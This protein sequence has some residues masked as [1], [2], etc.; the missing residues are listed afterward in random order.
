MTE[1]NKRTGLEIAITGMSGR[2]PGAG[3]I[4]QFWENLKNGVN[5]IRFFSD[6]ELLENPNMDPALLEA[7]NY[8]RATGILEGV[9]NFDAFFFGYSPLEAGVLDPQIRIFYE[10]CWEALEDGGCDP[11]SFSG[12]IGVY[13]GGSSNLSWEVLTMISGKNDLL[14]AF[15]AAIMN[16]KDYLGTRIAHKLDLKGPSL[17]MHTACSTSLVAVDLACR[18]L[19]TGQCDAAIA[20]GIC[21][22]PEGARGG[23]YLY[24]KDL[25][26][27]RDGFVRAFDAKASGV[28]FSQGGGAVLL[29]RLEDAIADG[30]NIYAVIKGFASNND[31]VDKSSFSAPSVDGQAACIQSALFMAEVDPQSITY[32][33]THGTGTSIGDPIEIEALNLAFMPDSEDD[34]YKRHSCAIGSLKTNIGHLDTGAGIVNLIKAALMITH[35]Q[36]PPSLNFETPNPKIDFENS[37]FYVNTRLQ[38]WRPDGYPLRA[39]VSS[40]GVGG[41]NA[42]VIV[43][44]PPRPQ[45][46]SPGRPYHLL[47]LSARSANAL[48]QTTKN[49]SDYLEK[50]P[51][52]NL[53]DVAFTLQTGRKA[54]EHKRMLVCA[55][56]GEALEILEKSGTENE[57]RLRTHYEKEKKRAVFMFPGQG[58][59]YVNMGLQLYRTEPVF[60]EET[61]R[62]FH[63]LEPA[64]GGGIKEILYPSS[65]GVPASPAAKINQTEITQPV[66]FTMEYALARLLM[67]WG[68]EPFAMI[69]HSIGEYVAACLSGVFS[70]EDALTLV[71]RRGKLMQQMPSGGML[72]IPLPEEDV[73]ELL[74][75]HRE[76]DLA[77]VNGPSLCV[78]SGP[79]GP[80]DALVRL[81][82]EKGLQY[83]R[84]HT[85]HAYHS[86]MME[87]VLS[88]FQENVGQVT[89]EEPRIPFISNITGQWIRP[90]EALDPGY[91][92]RH[93]RG[94]VRFADG[95]A[96]LLKE[97][98][99]VFI[100]VGPGRTLE[101]FLK[102]QP[103]KKAEQRSITLV[104]HPGEDVSDDYYLLDKIGQLWLYG[105]PTDWK[106]FY[107]AE[108][109]QRLRLPSYPFQRQPYWINGNP[110]AMIREGGRVRTTPG[111]K[112]DISDWFYIPA[113]KR[114][115]IER[116][117]APEPSGEASRQWLVFA[118]DGRRTV[119]AQL[120]KGL[121][122]SV[123]SDHI[124][125][126]E[127]SDAFGEF[128]GRYGA[129]RTYGVRP[130]HE[131]DYLRLLQALREADAVPTRIV[132]LWN[133]TGGG[134][135]AGQGYLP[136]Q[137]VEECLDTGFYSLLYLAKALG[138]QEISDEIQVTV[139]TDG[140]RDVWERD[141]KCPEKA[142][143]LGPLSVIPLEYPGIKCR[144][145]DMELDNPNVDRLLRDLHAGIT[146]G[147]FVIAY[148][149]R[150][151]YTGT[152]QPVRLNRGHGPVPG[153]RERGV[154]LITGGLG[155][156]GL[157]LARH[158]AKTAKARLILT[159]RSKFPAREEWEQRLRTHPGMDIINRKIRQLKELE[160]LGA[161]VRVY[162]VDSTDEAGMRRLVERVCQQWGSIHGVIHSAGLPG[163][164]LIQLKDRETADSVLA[165][166]IKGAL[167]LDAA[168][169]GMHPDFIVLCSSVGS[170]I[171]AI[172]QVDYFSANAFLDAFALYKNSLDGSSTYTVSINWDAW[173]E[174]GMAVEAARKSAASPGDNS[175]QEL[176]FL[177]IEHPL[178]DHCTAAGLPGKPG[179]E[180]YIYTTY[181][182]VNR[183]WVMS[184][185]RS[186]ERNGIVPGVTYL[187][188]AH[189]AVKNLLTKIEDMNNP[190]G[191]VEIRD[192]SFITPL[193]MKDGDERETRMVLT[194]KGDGHDYEFQ[195]R[196]RIPPGENK[197]EKHAAG[198]VAF[199][200]GAYEAPPARDLGVIEARCRSEEI[201][202]TSMWGADSENSMLLFGP[203]WGSLKTIK[204]GN[205]EGLALM[206]LPGQFLE[207]L[208]QYTLYPALLDIAAAF[209][210]GLIT[211]NNPYIPYSYKRLR[212]Y[213][214]LP[215]AIYAHGRLADG[216]DGTAAGDFLG[217]DVTVMDN[218]GEVLVEIEGFTM[219]EISGEVLGR[220]KAREH[221]DMPA[222]R[223]AG[224]WEEDSLDTP[225]RYDPSLEDGIAPAEG[226]EAF[227]RI[228]GESLPQVVVSTRDLAARIES[229]RSADVSAEAPGIPGL[230]GAGSADSV[231]ARPDMSVPYSA[232]T[233][234]VEQKMAAIW[235]ELLGIDQVGV[236]DDFFELGGDSLKA[237]VLIGKIKQEFDT[238][239]SVRQIFNSPR[240]R[241]LAAQLDLPGE[242]GETAAP[243]PG[244]TGGAVQPVEKRRFYPLSPMQK[245]M[246]VLSRM[247]G[248]GSTYNLPVAL[249]IDKKLDVRRVERTFDRL[250]RRHESLRT[251]FH[252]VD[253]QPV[254]V[255]HEAGEINFQV[256]FLVCRDGREQGETLVR[257]FIRPFDLS[258][259][260]LL[261]AQ[262]VELAG[263]TSM[264]IFDVHH[265]VVDGSSY[266]IIS[267]DFSSLYEDDE[268][269]GPVIQYKDFACWLNRELES[270]AIKQQ[271]E[272]WLAEFSGEIP[273]L[274]LPADY[275]RPPIQVFEGDVMS[276][277]VNEAVT[278]QLRE[279]AKQENV[280]LFMVLLAVY[281]VFLSRLSGQEDMVL[282]T[283]TAGRRLAEVQNVV[284]MFVNTLALRNYPAGGKRFKDFLNQVK[285]R[286]LEAF[287][288]QDYPF[289]ILVENV[290]VRRDA[291]RNPL[292]DVVIDLQSQLED[293]D[294]SSGHPV[295]TNT[296]VAKFDFKLTVIEENRR[297][298]GYVEYC[299]RL[300]KPQTIE[301]YIRYFKKTLISVL[302]NPGT[303]LNRVDILDS[304]EKK[305]LLVDF[306]DTAVEYPADRTLH[307]LFEAQVE[308]TPDHIA[309]KGDC[310]S[311]E[312]SLTYAGL[313]REA[314]RVACL[315]NERGVRL[316]DIVAL[317][318]ERSVAM[319]IGLMG[320]LKA[321]A[322]YLPIDPSYPQERV[323]YILADSAAV[324]L[325]TAGVMESAASD[326]RPVIPAA[327]NNLAYV[328]YTSGTTGRP[329]GVM[330]E[331]GN[332]VNTVAWFGRR[333]GIQPGVRVVMM[334]DYTFD[335]SVNQVF[336]TLLHGGELHVIPK[337]LVLDIPGLRNFIDSRRINIINFVPQLLEE[338]LTGDEKLDSLNVVLSGA[339]KLEDAVKDKIIDRGYELHN[340]YGPTEVT[341]DALCS[342]CRKDTPVHL[343]K[344]IDNVRCYILDRGGMPAPTGAAGELHVA[345]AGVARGYLNSPGSTHES[346]RVYHSY[347]PGKIYKTG[348]LARWL[349]DGNI[350][351]LGR[352]DHQLKIKG[353]RI[354][355]GEIE[356]RLLQYDE[357]KQ[358]IVVDRGEE[359]AEKHLCA[360]IVPQ[361]RNFEPGPAA[362]LKILSLEDLAKKGSSLPTA[363][364]TASS[365]DIIRGLENLA[366][367]NPDTV[368]AAS[369][370][371]TLG[372]ARCNET[373]NRLARRINQLYDDRYGLT[374][375]E[376]V[377]YTRQLKLDGW[378]LGSQER[379]KR[380]VVFVAGAGGIG[381]P[382]LQQLALAGVGS[383]IVCD[384]DNVELSNLNRQVLH[385]ESR[386]GMNKAMSAAATIRRIN[387]HVNVIPLAEK[388]TRDNIAQLAGRAEI[389]FDCVDDL[390][391]KFVLSEYA[392]ARE[393]PHVVS[394]MIDI[395]S[396]VIIMHT[397]ETPCYHCLTDRSKLDEVR[398]VKTAAKSYQRS[399]FPVSSPALFTCTGFAV[400]EALKILLG[401]ENPAYN[402]YFLFN[403][404]AS[405]RLAGTD[406]F[407]MNTYAYSDHFKKI[408]KEQGFDWDKA[409][410][411][412]FLE[413]L[414]IRPDPGCPVCS[415]G[416]R[417]TLSTFYGPGEKDSAAGPP[418]A[419]GYSEH[420]DI[421][422]V[423]L[424]MDDEIHRCT[425]IM[426]TLKA[427][428]TYF[429]LD[430]SLPE[431][432]LAALLEDSGAR[433]IVTG[434]SHMEAVVRLRDRVN[435]WIPV[436][437]VDDVPGSLPAENLNLPLAP[438]QPAALMVAANPMDNPG[439]FIEYL[440]Q[441]LAAGLPG[442]M[443]P[444]RFVLLEHLPLTTQGKIDRNAL[445]APDAA[446]GKEYAAPGNQVQEIL[447]S[448]WS[449]VL[450]LERVGINDNF[451]E[452]G[453]DSIKAIRIAARMRKHN[454]DLSINE[455]FLFPEIRELSRC[456]TAIDDSRP[457]ESTGED[458]GSSIIGGEQLQ[459]LEEDLV[460]IE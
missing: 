407:R 382:T 57:T 69:G 170:V 14:G 92:S 242:P 201:D 280:T 290:S 428:K 456:V 91:W 295:Q 348:D 108:K 130:G 458:D 184:E 38:E 432:K 237:A 30:D 98:H 279:L 37:R 206:E 191:I 358:A 141:V 136:S 102:R 437:D 54:F 183:H 187:E 56:I 374:R 291:S 67:S 176:Q 331:H 211:G 344:P 445:P 372:A 177:P 147:D 166:K 387:P 145:I 314:G 304:D 339:E 234:P 416:N 12:P 272:F 408:C 204:S 157:A 349:P 420:R 228:L 383:I 3:N 260:P 379:L 452:I 192:V 208:G 248:I 182:S 39:G 163:G 375:E 388:I 109:R 27:S 43:E 188:M 189:A 443:M 274:N 236:N 281:Y 155:G 76:L 287:E 421:R 350:E 273:V 235:E 246:Y 326:R 269:P 259:A 297:L 96:E 140:M 220:L 60:R 219:M 249:T 207:D 400:N 306:N 441:G 419:A 198:E 36:I 135:T 261:R 23:G 24:E 33:E 114:S 193:M 363:F 84:L 328:I 225:V 103:D 292:F 310:R 444:A 159:G 230:Q 82:E 149:G 406:G 1:D 229:A 126:V 6:E 360:Y 425:A 95:A 385:D 209:I 404:K 378:V 99:A 131:E 222:P 22:I 161:E 167:A 327:K 240:V 26:Y 78:V 18:G 423:A 50:N 172:G 435:R 196:S 186:R 265:I 267:K 307:A 422:P 94:T 132:H 81:L 247:G 158:L 357:V 298:V 169:R 238:A 369:G 146:G 257:Q 334:S 418:L 125:V 100:E 223:T 137:R 87:P 138:K 48:E 133:L 164:G 365:P 283:L 63:L 364:R 403:N 120:L 333:Y 216:Q 32:I 370:S 299:T 151:R 171:P 399:S 152:Y 263:E 440:Q 439:S 300:F 301:R 13:A 243:I 45:P 338:L 66:L 144:C 5:S 150:Y 252:M 97:K 288:N 293:W 80:V 430:A 447:A 210:C 398:A 239:M 75:G 368:V 270:G 233:N 202:L 313:N 195:V 337:N 200:P 31:G 111:K 316:E 354:E 271:E 446:P 381:S 289:E 324:F 64:M 253:D 286:S 11:S 345:G 70:L 153:V 329:R 217:F 454:L 436:I 392:V 309:V 459:K 205:N 106:A 162:S 312:G 278:A 173:K 180:V 308:K 117:G 282:G 47:V 277:T 264:V 362:H 28:V 352:L 318:M 401:L 266:I 65:P 2:F 342:R 107:A 175:S 16:D 190:G 68:I 197:W 322:A 305:R 455:I 325:L 335:A 71:A 442:Y 359:S 20:G 127:I 427:G 214:R 112:K 40:F 179:R 90:G 373:A 451:F 413:E 44:E 199:L 168:L 457:V 311:Q 426:G 72:S 448:I 88:A 371:R 46:V 409:W 393:I 115:V 302:E 255:V 178:F 414:I 213:R 317:R 83:R 226:V 41:T 59:Q 353:Y 129:A 86:R 124:T 254:Q 397:P 285:E 8:V 296:G 315:L 386:I 121:A 417:E 232:P 250:I 89:R 224:Q 194:P 154:Y 212:V 148:R 256:E 319:I 10:I 17:S 110:T 251:S 376:R 227:S 113:W 434:G 85:S 128:P 433:L 351:F 380:A 355:P 323:D 35:R 330:I 139:L 343:G 53:A 268:P 341:I 431:E 276:F 405:G 15:S 143:V 346:Y 221:G 74:A 142:L 460:D 42:H 394:V 203:R 122:G 134:N 390:E 7:P 412:N 415:R 93:L 21:V 104:R 347:S 29:K 396:Y 62:C 275:P 174:V 294:M 438:D 119:T 356:N 58:S 55:G 367:Q 244:K 79:H 336:G 77:A 361:P 453:G 165:P 185:H 101:T 410:R 52:V 218:K 377:R 332:A 366:R 25:I 321:G 51:G 391:T 303:A 123:S 389:L 429:S 258:K 449:D 411:G 395:C 181:F 49:F 34:A 241:E 61:D 156:I 118:G 9:E 284:G 340:Q 215:A 262:V 105:L 4:R 231:H 424:V 160:A 384:Y 320:I 402:K 245:R 19:L 73:M 450:G 116:G